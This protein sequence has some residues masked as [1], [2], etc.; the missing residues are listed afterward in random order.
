MKL[1]LGWSSEFSAELRRRMA[2]RG[3]SKMRLARICR[4][5]LPSA[6]KGNVGRAQ[7]RSIL[8]APQN[9]NVAVMYAVCRAL[10]LSMASAYELL[11]M[12]EAR[13]VR[14]EGLTPFE[15]G[16]YAAEQGEDITFCPYPERFN[17]EPFW[18]YLEWRDGFQSE[19]VRQKQACEEPVTDD[20]E[21]ANGDI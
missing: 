6:A 3:W 9:P 2:E 7:I 18:M 8:G 17:K 20:K 16:K 19:L 21:T 12:A 11:G 14:R 10:G 4:Q 5:Y 15:Q 1:D 13:R